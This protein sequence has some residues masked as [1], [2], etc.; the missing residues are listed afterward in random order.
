[1]EKNE[2]DRA[3]MLYYEAVNKLEELDMILEKDD[4]V[5]IYCDRYGMRTYRFIRYPIN[6]L[7]LM[8]EKNKRYEECLSIIE[9]YESLDD[10]FGLTYTD[11]ESIRKRKSRMLKK[12]GSVVG[13]Y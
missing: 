11:Q 5:K 10:K 6:R 4:F 8:L 1:M 3:I 13:P 2:P 9:K 12:R 7:S